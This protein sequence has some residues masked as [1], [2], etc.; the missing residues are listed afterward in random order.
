[1][2]N[3]FAHTFDKCFM[4]KGTIFNSLKQYAPARITA[5]VS[6]LSKLGC[7]SQMGE[8]SKSAVFSLTAAS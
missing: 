3:I 8:H 6:V 2:D 5:I 4:S 7:R 1:M